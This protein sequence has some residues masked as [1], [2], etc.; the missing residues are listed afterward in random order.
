[1][2]HLDGA[3]LSALPL[4]QRKAALHSLVSSTGDRIRYVDHVEGDGAAVFDAAC[5]LGAE[6]I[7]SKRGD[8]PHRGGRSADWIKTKCVRHAEFVVGGFTDRGRS[9]SDFGSLLLGY[10]D[11]ERLVF[12]GNVGTG[13]GLT[14]PVMAAL[15]VELDAL[16]HAECPFDVRPPRSVAQRA[17]W[18][19]PVLVADVAFT[20]F[21]R[22]G[23][24]R[25]P[26]LRALRANRASL[27]ALAAARLATPSRRRPE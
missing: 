8:R 1:V 25:H 20:E 22:G 15:R 5:K 27:S 21:T 13:K 12:A 19:R 3:A 24:L 23:H 9:R 16:E 11:A 7:V 17:H 2:L 6:G 26:T 4:V 18:V 10:V 14:Q